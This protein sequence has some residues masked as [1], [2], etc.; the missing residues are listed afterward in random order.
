MWKHRYIF[1][2]A[3]SRFANFR[4]LAWGGGANGIRGG[5]IAPPLPPPLWLRPWGERVR[6]KLGMV[7]SRNEGFLLMKKVR[8][9]LQ[10]KDG[11]EDDFATY[12]TDEVLHLIYAP[13]TSCDVERVF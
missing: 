7:L 9:M 11:A 12:F 5:G 10:G 13:I 3:S 4:K 2:N 1:S 6:A 8:N